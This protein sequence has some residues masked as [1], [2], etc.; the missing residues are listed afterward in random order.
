MGEYQE[1]EATL[2]RLLV[3]DPMTIVGRSNYAGWLGGTG[4]VEEGHE[5]WPTSYSHKACGQGYMRHAEM[6]LN[7]EGRIG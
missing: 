7:Y 6:S 3:T 5:V 4:R 1:Q 2:K